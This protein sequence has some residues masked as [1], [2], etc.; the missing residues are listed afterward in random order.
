MIAW[1]QLPAMNNSNASSANPRDWRRIAAFIKLGLCSVHL[2][3]FPDL[4]HP[5]LLG[6]RQ[7]AGVATAHREVLEA[8]ARQALAVVQVAPIEDHRSV[9]ALVD[10]VEVRCLELLPFRCR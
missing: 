8:F 2:S 3:G 6:N 7:L 10:Q 9:Q 4:R 5:L 1:C